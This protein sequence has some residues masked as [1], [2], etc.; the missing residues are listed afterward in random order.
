M[1][2]TSSQWREPRLVIGSSTSIANPSAAPL[3]TTSISNTK[4]MN[5]RVLY[6]KIA[7]TTARNLSNST[8]LSTWDSQDSS[9]T[10]TLQGFSF[11]EHNGSRRDRRLRQS[12]T[13][14]RTGCLNCKRRRIKCEE[15]RPSCTQCTKRRLQCEWPEVQI[16][17]R[18]AD[19]QIG[20][21]NP[22]VPAQL[23]SADAA[24]TMQD[25][26]LFYYFIQ[27]AYPHHP[28]GN[29][30]VWTHEIPSI[31]HNVGSSIFGSTR[32]TN[33]FK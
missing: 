14:S 31:S 12:H 5:E 28:I 21:S 8:D 22:S 26:R 15:N 1:N 25:F 11:H 6:P 3:N 24:F 4:T 33:D 32:T 20:F 9:G 30:S 17:D 19:M 27:K 13:K 23:Q 10:D 29:D 7:P 16:R 2:E 18:R